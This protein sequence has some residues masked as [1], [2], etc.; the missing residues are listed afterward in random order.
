M[1]ASDA[2]EMDL[3][4]MARAAQHDER[5]SDGALFG[6]L[7]DEIERLRKD[8]TDKAVAWD[9]IADKN[10]KIAGW[11]ANYVELGHSLHK[12]RNRALIAEARVNAEIER[13]TTALAYDERAIQ[14]CNRT[15]R[16]LAQHMKMKHPTYSTETAKV[17]TMTAS[18]AK[19]T[20]L[21]KRLIARADAQ[22][23]LGNPE[24]LGYFSSTDEKIL[25]E[26]AAEIERLTAIL[27]QAN[28]QYHLADKRALA[29]ESRVKSLLQELDRGFS[30][31]V[32]LAAAMHAHRKDNEYLLARAETAE[33]R[34][35]DVRGET[36]AWVA[37]ADKLEAALELIAGSSADQLKAMQA[38]AA[39]ET[40][41]PKLALTNKGRG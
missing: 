36:S 38:R 13:L 10:A 8:T 31:E 24:A 18:D 27:A 2:K 7:A 32:E 20:D 33:S 26:A 35:R 1:T 5:L 11:S 6:K 15:V 19:E 14:A 28:H 3:V 30:S 39:L 17:Q 34:A 37:Y 22:L 29:A 23:H 16:Q 41:R 40:E 4:I 12:W 9:V 25:R 21:V